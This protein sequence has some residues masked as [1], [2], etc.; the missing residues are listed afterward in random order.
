LTGALL[1]VGGVVAAEGE[2]LTPGGSGWFGFEGYAGVSEEAG[3]E[4]G[5]VL[6]SS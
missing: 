2:R 5:L 3:D 6:A 1:G 4:V